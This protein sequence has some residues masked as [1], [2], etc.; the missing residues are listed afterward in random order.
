VPS[1]GLQG[2]RVYVFPHRGEGQSSFHLFEDDGYSVN[3]DS[4]VVELT[5][6]CSA[7]IISLNASAQV[8]WVLPVHEKRMVVR[9]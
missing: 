5:M 2:R 4:N 6:R 3:G 9:N 1:Q 8:E 7:E